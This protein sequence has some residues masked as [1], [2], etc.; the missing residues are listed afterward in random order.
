M[1][2]EAHLSSEP[3]DWFTL[4]MFIVDDWERSHQRRLLGTADT[5][6]LVELIAQGLQDAYQLGARAAS[7]AD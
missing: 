6:R 7:R 4:A 2:R 3:P 1:P 5:G